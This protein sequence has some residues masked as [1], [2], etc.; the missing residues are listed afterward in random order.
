MNKQETLEQLSAAK[1]A[2]IKWVN[3][4]KS[5]VEGLPVEKDAIPVDSTECQFGQWFYGEGQQLNALPS[6]ECMGKIENLHFALHDNYMKIFKLYFGEPNRSFFSKIF[7]LK[8]KISDED[9]AT[10]REY[11]VKLE[12]VSKQLLDEIGRLERRLHAMSSERF[13]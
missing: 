11:Y 2:H 5:L 6:M 7:N 1:K 4:A 13:E 9:K 10:A 8:P 3:R 12:E